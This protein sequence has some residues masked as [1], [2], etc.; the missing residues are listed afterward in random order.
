MSIWTIVPRIPERRFEVLHM[1][2]GAYIGLK[3]EALR[4]QGI[5]DEGRIVDHRMTEGDMPFPA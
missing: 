5:L 4:D 3:Y 1:S 2:A